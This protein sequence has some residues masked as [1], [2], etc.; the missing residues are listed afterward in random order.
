MIDKRKKIFLVFDTETV[1]TEKNALIYDLGYTIIDKSGKIYCQQNF[2]ISEIYDNKPLME[3]AYFYSKMAKYEKMLA[4]NEIEKV[5]F[6]TAIKVLQKDIQDFNVKT[7]G[8]YNIEFDLGALTTTTQFIF[9]KV[10][11]M[12][13]KKTKN[14]LWCPDFEKFVLKYICKKNLEILCIW[15]LACQTIF[16]QK[17]FQTYF[18]KF[19]DKNNFI[20]NAELAYNYIM[21]TEDFIEDHTALS[22]TVI[23]CQILVRCLKIHKSIE[24]GIIY[25]PFKKVKKVI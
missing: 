12:L 6:A 17:T 21:N 7:L 18:A 19:T 4:N 13:F 1:G 10:F 22:D 14:N 8:A 23:E 25:M 5:S 24:K 3:S 9:P 11:K 2:L 15:G 20:T 16:Q